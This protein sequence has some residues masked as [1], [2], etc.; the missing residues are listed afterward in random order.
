VDFKGEGDQVLNPVKLDREIQERVV[1]LE[2][3]P[4]PAALTERKLRAVIGL[5][6]GRQGGW[7]RARPW[8]DSC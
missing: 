5:S 6:P 2:E 8:A 1:K 4:A 7:I 3:P